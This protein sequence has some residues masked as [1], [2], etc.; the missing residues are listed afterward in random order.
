MK[1]MLAGILVM[2]HLTGCSFVQTKVDEALDLRSRLQNSCFTFDTRVT[3]DY[4]DKLY[5]FSMKCDVD[6]DG[7]L[8][9]QVTSPET[10]EGIS[11]NISPEGG[12][13][14]FDDKVL[15]FEPIADG[16]V[17]PV[18][19]PWVAIKALKGGY[20][21]GCEKYEQGIHIQLNDSYEEETLHLDVWTDSKNLPMAAHIY[22]E[23]RRILSLEIEN[24]IFL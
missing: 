7:K 6:A 11:G 9:F 2:L 5:E 18:T 10:L 20:I 14:T 17:T 12:K 3:A 21:K 13:F 23:G 16:L 4:L 15:L 24:F 1:R 22:W 8:L 19:A